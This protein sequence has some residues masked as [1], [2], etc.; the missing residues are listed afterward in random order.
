MRVP[1]MYKKHVAV[2]R[3]LWL[4][5]FISTSYTLSLSFFL[6]ISLSPSLCHK[7]IQRMHLTCFFHLLLSVVA[8]FFNSDF[9]SPIIFTCSF[10]FFFGFVS[11]FPLLLFHF[12][13]ISPTI[14]LVL[15]NYSN[16]IIFSSIFR[17][18]NMQRMSSLSLLVMLLA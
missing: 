2:C 18:F 16:F 1:L 8:V 11:S 4:V 13:H 7:H 9:L 14:Y 17:A 6:S 10:F 12:V 5:F 3:T 15:L